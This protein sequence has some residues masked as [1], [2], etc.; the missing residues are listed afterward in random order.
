[1]VAQH[2]ASKQTC[3]D[4][5]RRS[6]GLWRE[7]ILN[8]PKVPKLLRGDSVRGLVDWLLGFD[9]LQ[10]L[11]QHVHTQ[12]LQLP[13]STR[14]LRFLNLTVD[15]TPVFLN[16]IPAHG[17]LV[18][19]ANHPFGIVEGFAL[20]ELVQ[21]VRPDVKLMSTIMLKGL[22]NGDEHLLYVDNTGGPNA[23]STNRRGLTE[24]LRWL[25]NDRGALIVFPA[26][27]VSRWDS[28]K[29]QPIDLDWAPNVGS[30]V[31][32]SG[33]NVLPAFVEG[34]NSRLFYALGR[35]SDDLHLFQ[36]IREFVNKRD[37]S[38]H[39]RLGPIVPAPLIAHMDSSQLMSAL[40]ES[41]E[42]LPHCENIFSQS[43]GPRQTIA[44]AEDPEALAKEVNQILELG[45]T[46]S[47]LLYGDRLSEKPLV[48]LMKGNESEVILR[49]LGRLRETVFRAIGEGSGQT[50]DRDVFD[51]WYWHVILWDP[52]SKRIGGAY[53]AYGTDQS[54]LDKMLLAQ[55]V[56][57]FQERMHPE[58]PMLELGRAFVVPE[59]KGGLDLLWKGIGSFLI[60][61]PQ[62]RKLIGSVSMSQKMSP[63][64]HHLLVNFLRKNRMVSGSEIFLEPL[65]PFVLPSAPFSIRW[66][67]PAVDSA[68]N[69][70]DLSH[71]FHHIESSVASHDLPEFPQLIKHYGDLLGGR[72][73]T[74]LADRDFGSIDALFVVD[75]AKINPIVL[76]R[77]LG[78]TL[79]SYLAHKP[80]R[81]LPP[82]PNSQ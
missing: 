31:Q 15:A 4:E 66:L 59:Y 63:Y 24:A 39:V 76:G 18:I 64:S 70:K 40:R 43:G 6:F 67:E 46:G 36:L 5:L 29:R 23:S 16:Q 30:L 37:R 75:V 74:F 55:F 77:F 17:P 25:K 73:V 32:K 47:R 28:K 42:C 21:K 35:F 7:A 48:L 79:N 69:G 14:I 27:A 61:N 72:V 38:I 8:N 2:S 51:E 65:P 81:S 11:L 34:Q 9:R 58:D 10:A 20:L 49:E 41:S 12:D 50:Y 53:R 22:E 45:G 82:D 60:R 54:T 71:W 57:F 52:V 62:Y 44:P 68:R 80:Q 26:G 13:L 56:R 19:V 33:A 78:P 3:A 1:L